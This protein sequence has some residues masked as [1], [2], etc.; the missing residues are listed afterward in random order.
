MNA[1]RTSVFEG[2]SIVAPRDSIFAE[3]RSLDTNTIMSTDRDRENVT[4]RN[5]KRIVYNSLN[6]RTSNGEKLP[7]LDWDRVVNPS[8][9][10]KFS[11]MVRPIRASGA[12]TP[13]LHLSKLPGSLMFTDKKE[14]LNVPE[15]R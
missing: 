12:A 6:I 14:H 10:Q 4:S 13:S 3:A 9:L 1:T 11:H 8:K 2:N 5:K 7:I 15:I